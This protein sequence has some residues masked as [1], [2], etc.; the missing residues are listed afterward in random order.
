LV[1]CTIIY[2]H[3]YQSHPPLTMVLPLNA[4]CST[5]LVWPWRDLGG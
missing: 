1:G 5:E 3:A 4:T 2:Q